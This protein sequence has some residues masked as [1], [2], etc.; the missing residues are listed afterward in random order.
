M[1]LRDRFRIDWPMVL[2][3]LQKRG[4]TLRQIAE[5]IGCSHATLSK[6]NTGERR[7]AGYDIGAGALHLLAITT[8]SGDR[9]APATT[10]RASAESLP[11]TSRTNVGARSEENLR[12]GDHSHHESSETHS[13]D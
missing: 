9:D 4:M 10:T 5:R 7:V 3:Q 2:G 1:K 12:G 6:L 11:Q 13:R 8:T